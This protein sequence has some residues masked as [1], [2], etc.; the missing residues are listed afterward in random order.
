MVLE[1]NENG[2]IQERTLVDVDEVRKR[3]T[4]L[5]ECVQQVDLQIAEMQNRKVEMLAEIDRIKAILGA[6]RKGSK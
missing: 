1:L 6:Y 2:D 5:Q 4:M 3:L